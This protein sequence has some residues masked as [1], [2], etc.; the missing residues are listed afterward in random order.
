[1]SMIS[2]RL[3]FYQV[4]NYIS[5]SALIC[6]RH[7]CIKIDHLVYIGN[8]RRNMKVSQINCS[9]WRKKHNSSPDLHKTTTQPLQNQANGNQYRHQTQPRMIFSHS[10]FFYFP[11]QR[12]FF[13]TSC[14]PPFYRNKPIS[15]PKDMPTIAHTPT[16][17]RVDF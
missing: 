15:F 10:T 11:L 4:M 14:V 1:M 7:N 8:N 6:L 2:T 9:R 13:C 17:P 5:N 16:S 12:T 3:R